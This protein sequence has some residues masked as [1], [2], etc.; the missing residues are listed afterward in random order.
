MVRSV[1][2]AKQ[3][4]T[5]P[6]NR[7]D[8]GFGT[9]SN[10]KTSSLCNTRYT[11]PDTTSYYTELL[12]D[13]GYTSVPVS[14]ARGACR[15]RY[16][17]SQKTR[18]YET[19][20]RGRAPAITPAETPS[21]TPRTD[22]RT[23]ERRA[24]VSRSGRPPRRRGRL[25]TLVGRPPLR[26]FPHRASCCLTCSYTCYGYDKCVLFCSTARLAPT[27]QRLRSP[28]RSVR[29]SLLQLFS[30]QDAPEYAFWQGTPNETPRRR[31]KSAETPAGTPAETPFFR[32]TLNAISSLYRLRTALYAPS[33]HSRASALSG[34]TWAAS[35]ERLRETWSLASSGSL[36]H[37]LL[38]IGCTLAGFYLQLVGFQLVGLSHV[39]HI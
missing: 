21:E 33:S 25:E 18:A 35:I 34:G 23:P 26:P 15:A 6:A 32:E 13:R 1:S 5:D 11:T 3:G 30:P 19:P 37:M 31:P 4:L 36:Q 38:L 28:K 24:S 7:T 10:L 8:P 12:F 2:R 27:F 9:P 20:V 14:G 17:K 22:A 39:R 29:Y 16:S